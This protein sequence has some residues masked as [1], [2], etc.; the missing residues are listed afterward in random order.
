M[1]YQERASTRRRLPFRWL[2]LTATLV[3][4][5]SPGAMADTVRPVETPLDALA[6]TAAIVEGTVKENSYTFDEKAGPRTVVPLVDITTDF[7]RFEERTLELATLGGPINEKQE[8]YVPELPQLTDDTRYLV[9]LTNVDW[10]FSPVVENYVFRLEKGPRGTDVLIAPSG[11]AVEGLTADG[12]E[13]SEEPVVDTQID[14][15]RPNV[16]PRLVENADQLLTNAMSKDAFLAAVRDLLRTIPLQ[17][18]FRG[19][20]A[21]DRVWNQISTA[22]LR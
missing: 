3:V 21:R 19:S 22:P 15:S 9:F 1:R 20:P 14:A 11:H 6:N 18:E 8:L 16:K 10:F 13:F 5:A 4:S 12:L 2:V 17:G 7:G